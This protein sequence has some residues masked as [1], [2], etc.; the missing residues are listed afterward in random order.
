[1]H[2]RI[3]TANSKFF[4]LNAEYYKAEKA[5]KK[6]YFFLDY[7][8]KTKCSNANLLDIGGGSGTF[9]DLVMNECPD[10]DVTVLDPSKELLKNIR[11]KH[12][13]TMLGQLPCDIDIPCTFDYIHIKNVIHHITGNSILESRRLFEESLRTVKNLLKDDGVLFL[14]DEFDEGYLI[15]TLPRTLIFYTL[16]MQ[17]KL[18]LKIPAK[19]FLLGLNVCFY[20]RDEL[21][22]ITKTNGFEICDS[23]IDYWGNTMKKKALLIKNWGRILLILRKHT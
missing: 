5:H 20:T 4:D 1:M 12:I 9:A 13:K 2:E 14:H 8:K 11:N 16:A 3:P 15:P 6:D 18:K 19:E 22:L 7:I 21:N 17:N 10:I 23:T